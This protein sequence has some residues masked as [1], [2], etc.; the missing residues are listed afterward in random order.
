MPKAV[1]NGTLIWKY[2]YL[3]GILDFGND[4]GDSFDDLGIREIFCKGIGDVV[5]AN[6][7]NVKC[8]SEALLKTLNEDCYYYCLK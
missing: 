7:D 2:I 8:I 3:D 6:V 1:P 4:G 5:L